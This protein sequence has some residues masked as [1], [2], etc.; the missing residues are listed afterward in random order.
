MTSLP[1]AEKATAGNRRVYFGAGLRRPDMKPAERTTNDDVVAWPALFFDF[2]S[3]EAAT[4]GLQRAKEIGLDFHYVVQ[5]G[6]VR[7]GGEPDLRVQCWAL[8]DKPC[9]DVGRARN[10]LRN[11]IAALGSDKTIHDPRRDLRERRI[12]GAGPV[13]VD[14]AAF[15]LEARAL[16]HSVP[17]VGYRL[18]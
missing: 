17:T 4:W 9:E 11:G 8:L 2:D 1:S 14:A 5:T 12:R 3:I 13:V 10:I 15:R 7:N 6:A 18:T 16:S